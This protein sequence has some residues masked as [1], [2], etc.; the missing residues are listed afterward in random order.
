MLD[1]AESRRR[2]GL[3]PE[4]RLLI[5]VGHLIER[6]GHDLMLRALSSIRAR[7]L[8]ARAMIVGSGPLGA[9]LKALARSLGLEPFV[10]W[11]GNVPHAELAH[12]YAAADALVLASSRE[13]WANVLLE[14]LACGTPVVATAVFGTPEVIT[15]PELGL[16]VHERSAEAIGAALEQALA[17]TFDRRRL[18]AH[19]EAHSWDATARGVFD[20]FRA[21]SSDSRGGPR[22]A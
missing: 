14:A 16:L 22:W 3:P 17:R 13:G 9:E 11:I 20:V 1:R 2:L 6:K 10:T 15:G 4:G 7:G 5:S 19:A 21:A 12:H 18:R 8:D